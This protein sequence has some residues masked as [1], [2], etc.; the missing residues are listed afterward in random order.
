M[1]FLFVDR[2]VRLEPGRDALVRKNVSNSEDFFSDHFSGRPVMPGCLILETGD[3]VAR[4]LLA[5]AEDFGRLPVLVEVTNG[6][7]QH[8]VQPG[9]TLEVAASVARQT[10]ASAEVRIQASVEGRRVAA[11]TLAYRF[12]EAASDPAAARAC[13]RM[14]EF[15]A[16]IT[17]R[18][19]D[20]AR[21]ADSAGEAGHA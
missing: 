6:K 17:S 18:P 19:P 13:R 7:F 12:S 21:T 10:P 15:Y 8:F 16:M 14:R 4:L 9:D 20:G 11:A 5:S 1:R 3:Q 2:I